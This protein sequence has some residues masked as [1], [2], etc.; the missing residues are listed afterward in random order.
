MTSDRIA[1]PVTPVPGSKRAEVDDIAV[2]W[3]KQ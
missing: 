3:R 2:F 1:E